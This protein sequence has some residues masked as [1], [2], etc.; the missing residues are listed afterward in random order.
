MF[1]KDKK[2]M[3]AASVCTVLV[4]NQLNIP[5]KTHCSK[6]IHAVTSQS[7]KDMHFSPTYPKPE[8]P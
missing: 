8:E 1:S 7:V 5:A 3:E 4:P 2:Q 6:D